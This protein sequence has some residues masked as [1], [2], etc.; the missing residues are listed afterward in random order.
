MEDSGLQRTLSGEYLFQSIGWRNLI[1][2][3]GRDK[4]D[5]L[6]DPKITARRRRIEWPSIDEEFLNIIKILR[7]TKD[8]NNQAD[9]SD[10]AFAREVIG[11]EMA[12][13]DINLGHPYDGAITTLYNFGLRDPVSRVLEALYYRGRIQ[14]AIWDVFTVLNQRGFL[15]LD[16]LRLPVTIREGSATVARVTWLLNTFQAPTHEYSPEVSANPPHS[17][18]EEYS[19]EEAISWLATMIVRG[20][21]DVDQLFETIEA[22]QYLG[23]RDENAFSIY[24]EQCKEKSFVC[25]PLERA[26]DEMPQCND[27]GFWLPHGLGNGSEDDLADGIRDCIMRFNAMERAY[28]RYFKI[29]DEFLLTEEMQ[30][31]YFDTHPEKLPGYLSKERVSHHDRLFSKLPSQLGQLDEGVKAEAI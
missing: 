27:F 23:A 12:K 10:I 14:S 2:W 29:K 11:S 1:S 7:T 4:I 6:Y 3:P 8:Q 13:C 19:T 20:C 21:S 15:S 31:P 9:P 16:C 26:C 30:V 25:N 28:K 22:S 18:W 5:I 24:M 17:L